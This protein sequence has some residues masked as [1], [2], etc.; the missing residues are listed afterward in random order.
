MPAPVPMQD[1][2]NGASSGLRVGCGSANIWL[3]RMGAESL[4]EQVKKAVCAYRAA[5]DHY[6]RPALG[7]WDLR[8]G[9]RGAGAAGAGAGGAGSVLR[10]GRVGDPSRSSRWSFWPGDRR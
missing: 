8:R 7:F 2:T 4:D 1:T 3:G 10:G 9:D 5:A 6:S